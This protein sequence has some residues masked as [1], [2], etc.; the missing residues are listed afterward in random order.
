M[1]LEL[2]AIFVCLSA[3][4]FFGVRLFR[5]WSLRREIL[6][7]PNERSS[8]TIPTPR[9]G[10][11]VIAAVCLIAYLT[12]GILGPEQLRWGYVAGASMIAVVSWIDDLY[13]VPPGWRFLLHAASVALMLLDAGY[14][15]QISVWHGREIRLPASIGLFVTAIWLLWMINAYN[16]MDGIDGLAGLQAVIAGLSWAILGW[17]LGSQALAIYA[18]VVAA[19]GFGFL[20]C[21]W[22]PAKIF[23]GDV[24]S[25]FLGFTFGSLPLMAAR[26]I[27][28]ATGE[29]PAAGILFVWFFFFDTA[30]T[31][32]RR[33]LRGE[34]FWEPHREHI[35][36]RMTGRGLSHTRVAVAY[37]AAA[38]AISAVTLAAVPEGGNLLPLLVFIILALSIVLYM[39]AANKKALT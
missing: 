11:L 21:N 8:H 37:G 35:Y 3:V 30:V 16:F 12:I 13:S 1:F 32:L 29:M 39:A 17:L 22:H 20:L 15:A 33:I 4:S 23:M 14:F 7:Y 19:A 10:G 38:A 31:L 6:D 24:G 28:S 26:E 25:A 34:R 9:G 27:P 36:Q 5:R 2:L 18:L